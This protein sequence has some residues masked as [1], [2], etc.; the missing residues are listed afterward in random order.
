MHAASREGDDSDF[1]VPLTPTGGPGADVGTFR[2]DLP[3]GEALRLRRAEHDV[4]D[5][6]LRVPGDG[7]PVPIGRITRDLADRKKTDVYPPLFLD[8]PDRGTTRVRPFFTVDN[9]L[10]LSA[11]DSDAAGT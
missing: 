1:T 8:H 9:A 7:P 5:L 3:Y 11:R 4:W 2:F 10:A 6:T